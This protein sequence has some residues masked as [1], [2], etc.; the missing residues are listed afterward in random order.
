MPE[1][2]G[3]TTVTR[4]WPACSR[5]PRLPAV[6]SKLP[7]S[8]RAWWRSGPLPPHR[9]PLPADLTERELEILRRLAAGRTKREIAAELTISHSTVHTRAG[10]G[11]VR[12]AARAGRQNRLTESIEQ[13]IRR[14]GRP[15]YGD[16]NARPNRRS[17]P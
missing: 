8:R 16:V 2:A 3:Y 17:P 4:C 13:S 5:R 14:A 12:D 1:E 9:A 10:S 7:A 11:H 6:R 15:S